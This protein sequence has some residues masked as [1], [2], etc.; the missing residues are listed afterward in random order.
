MSTN[1][2]VRIVAEAHLDLIRVGIRGVEAA[3]AKGGQEAVVYGWNDGYLF[4]AREAERALAAVI[5][6]L[7]EAESGAG[8]DAA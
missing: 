8:A 5:A 3:A 7:A 1:E 6:K 4:A 2:Y